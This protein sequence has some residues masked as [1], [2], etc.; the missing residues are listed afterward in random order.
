[1]ERS[2]KE[3]PILFDYPGDGLSSVLFFSHADLPRLFYSA[4]RSFAEINGAN[5]GNFWGCDENSSG[6]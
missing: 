3:Y 6:I 5:E 2:S 4:P 1:V